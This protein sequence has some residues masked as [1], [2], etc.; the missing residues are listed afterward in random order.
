MQITAR[1]A[2]PAGWSPG[3]V[4]PTAS[5]RGPGLLRGGFDAWLGRAER[6]LGGA[7]LTA[8][9]VATLAPFLARETRLAESIVRSDLERVRIHVSGLAAGAGN[10]A[11]T[12][13]P[14]IYVSDAA[15]ATRM[16]SWEGRR[17]L[18]HEL[19][20][21]IQWRESASIAATDAQRDRT[22]LIAY[23][24]AYLIHDG[25]LR[26][27]GFANALRELARRREAGEAVGGVGDLLHDTHPMEQA[28]ERV[29]VAFRD[30]TT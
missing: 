20:H 9:Q 24:G 7:A 25:R 27:G 17:W 15:R 2:Q 6:S 28:A 5:T 12:I 10:M 1:I 4:N 14:N 23:V 29:A 11:T 3:V 21:T 8:V 18:A 19:V 16:L 13:G 26:D 22:F 30:A